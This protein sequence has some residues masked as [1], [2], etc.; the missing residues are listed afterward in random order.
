MFGKRNQIILKTERLSLIPLARR[1]EKE[2]LKLWGD[3]DIVRYMN[4][5]AYRRRAECRMRIKRLLNANIAGGCP[6]QFVLLLG[7][8]VVGLAGF[9]LDKEEGPQFGLYYLLLK[10]YW[11]QGYATE[12]AGAVLA[13]LF[14]H[15]PAAVV[16]GD[17][18]AD[19]RASVAVLEKL[20]FKLT[21][22]EAGAFTKNG[23]GLDILHFRL[24]ANA[25]ASA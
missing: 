11:G 13:Y 2:M 17:S 8:E 14:E 25:D 3:P 7:Q 6:N 15:Y 5:P 16:L 4:L 24:Q 21:R 10:K 19:N 22:K 9:P 18:V 23:E 1:H 12:A 20:G